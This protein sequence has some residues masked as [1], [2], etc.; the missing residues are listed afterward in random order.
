[1][2]DYQ[3]LSRQFADIAPHFFASRQQEIAQAQNAWLS[4]LQKKSW[5]E[6]TLDIPGL[7]SNVQWTGA[8]DQLYPLGTPESFYSVLGVDGS[9]IYADRHQGIA[10]SLL[11]IARVCFSYLPEQSNVS[12]STQPFLVSEYQEPRFLDIR[13]SLLELQ[14]GIQALKT[15]A[16]PKKTDAPTLLLFDGPICPSFLQED[17]AAMQQQ[18]TSWK[19]QIKELLHQ[20]H[21]QKLLI[22]GYTSLPRAR[23]LVR[24]L[25]VVAEQQGVCTI[26]AYEQ[27]LDADLVSLFLQPEFRS[28]WFMHPDNELELPNMLRIYSAYAHVGSEIVRI[29]LPGYLAHDDEQSSLLMRMI[30]DQVQKGYG[31]PVVLAEAHEHA[32]IREADRQL[33]YE[34]ATRKARELGIGLSA[35]CKS[36]KK[37]FPLV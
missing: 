27:V 8:I 15:F 16:D 18:I 1:M 6:L 32:V 13:R 25:E 28:T 29:E 20:C 35:S 10:W 21:E 5:E 2:I 37:R 26:P 36:V 31:Y 34:L 19:T 14:T 7:S 17:T 11:T 12:F 22:A 24:L 4:C 30:L 33:F 9:Q 23:H 3:E